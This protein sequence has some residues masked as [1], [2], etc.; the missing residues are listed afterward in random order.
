MLC[1]YIPGSSASSSLPDARQLYSRLCLEDALLHSRRD[2]KASRFKRISVASEMNSQ[3]TY[4]ARS[5]RGE[6]ARPLRDWK[7]HELPRRQNWI[8]PRGKCF[9]HFHSLYIA[10]S[11]SPTFPLPNSLFLGSSSRSKKLDYQ[12]NTLHFAAELFASSALKILAYTAPV[13]AA[14]AK[15]VCATSKGAALFTWILPRLPLEKGVAG[16]CFR[17]KPS[18]NCIGKARSFGVLIS[19]YGAGLRRDGS[20]SGS[21]CSS[22][23]YFKVAWSFVYVVSG[24]WG[25]YNYCTTF[26]SLIFC[27]CCNLL[28]F[29]TS[30]HALNQSFDKIQVRI[31]YINQLAC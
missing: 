24:N 14:F 28:Y 8:D 5:F 10:I 17:R 12:I 20:S 26:A 27:V 23:H 29:Y 22:L 13:C 15:N 3:R 11:S 21:N 25:G 4:F 2:E 18:M 30:Y 19:I 9:R 1:Q 16:R 6:F 31:I 7:F